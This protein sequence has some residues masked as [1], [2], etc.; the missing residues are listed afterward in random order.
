[1]HVAPVECSGCSCF[2]SAV[3]GGVIVVV[4]VIFLVAVA[5][6]VATVNS[7]I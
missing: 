5:A 6:G 2:S 4:V 3:G 7:T 1:M